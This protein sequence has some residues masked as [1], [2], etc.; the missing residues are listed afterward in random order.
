MS[1][2]LSRDLT[3]FAACAAPFVLGSCCSER[4]PG[5]G[6]SGGSNEPTGEVPRGRLVEV[7]AT[8]YHLNPSRIYAE[9]G[10]TLTLALR[11]EGTSLHN[12]EIDLGQGDRRAF[13]WSIYPHDTDTMTLTVPTTS[14]DFPYYSPIGNH[15]GLGMGGTLTVAPAPQVRLCEVASGLTAPVAMVVPP[16]GSGR[17]FLVDQIGVIRILGADGTLR[18]RPFLD[19]RNRMVK[20]AADYDER[21]LL[22]LA[23]HPGYAQNG[24]FFIHY[25]APRRPEAPEGFDTTLHVSELHASATDA[26]SADPASERVLL[27]IDHPQKNHVAGMIAFGPDDGFL[28]IAEGDGGGSG[29][30]GPGHANVIGNAQDVTTLLGK[31]LRLDVDHGSPY[32]IPADNPFATCGGAPEIYAWGF[33]NPYRFSFDAGGAHQLFVGDA[34][35]CIWEEVSL[36]ERGGNYGWNVLEGTHCFAADPFYAA[37]RTCQQTDTRGQPLRWPVIEIPNA[38]QPGGYAAAIIGGYV[39]RGAKIPELSGHYV[40][41][42]WSRRRDQRDGALFMASAGTPST[43]LWAVRRIQLQGTPSGNV[44]RYVRGFGQ[45]EENELY[46]L[47]S[48]VAGPYGATGRVFRVAPAGA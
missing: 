16:D 24:R 5:P 43:D 14:G 34:G 22:G 41:G 12:L 20:L 21:G 25:T 37:L 39:Y 13:R 9:P 48:E 42:V 33:R 36:V 2:A 46:V 45:D 30:V 15:R 3:L 28:Y 7:I 47:T 35:Q 19:V 23:F 38:H 18:G 1:N 29:D 32:A 26:D 8:E 11:N 27:A 44:G 4:P 40:F 17:R 31:I 6:G 10:E